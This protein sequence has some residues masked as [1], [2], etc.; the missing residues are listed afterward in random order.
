[1]AFVVR[2]KDGNTKDCMSSASIWQ[3]AIVHIPALLGLGILIY[4]AYWIVGL[5]RQPFSSWRDRLLE[6]SSIKPEALY[7]FRFSSL[8][9]ISLAS[10]FL[11]L[12]LV[13][14]IAS[15]I[16]VFAYFKSL[17]LIACFLGFGLGCY[18][19]RRKVCLLYALGPL[20]AMVALVELP[21]VPLRHLVVNLSGFIGWFSDVHVWGRAYFAGNMLWGWTSAAIA[22][23][24]VIALFGLIAITFV[25]F[26]QLVGWY[27]ER[28]PK[29]ILGYSINVLASVIGIWIYTLLCFLSTPPFV[30]FTLL[31]VGLAVFFWRSRPLR[32]LVVGWSAA[33]LLLFVTG[34]YRT[35]WW[36]EESWK[37]SR[38][39]VYNEKPGKT[40]IFW[41]PYQKLTIV[42]LL[43]NQQVMRYVLNTNDSWYQEVSN[44][45]PE[46]VAKNPSLNVL[47]VPLQFHQ[48]NLP[49]RFYPNPP[50]VLIAGAGMGNDVAGALRNGAGDITAVE[51]DPLIYARGKEL[52]PERPYSSDRVHVR[53]DDAR[54]FIQNTNE[55]F[56]LII[57]SILDSH[58]TSSYY[59]NIRLDNY[60]YTLEAMQ[61]TRT[62]LKPDGVFVM[63]FSSERPWFAGRLRGIVE[64]AFR[65]SPLMVHLAPEFFIVG[66]GH[67]IERA[68]AGNPE[69]K[70]IVE[71]R[72]DVPTAT[73]ELS[74][75][76]WPYLYQQ[77]RGV[78]TI[79]WLLSIGLTLIC[80]M[81]FRRLKSSA[82]GV[83]LH[84][85]FLGAA[86]MLLEV[87][88]ISKAALLF[89]T[90]WLVNSIVISSLLLFILCSNL[91]ISRFPNFP[92]AVAY[93]GL[94]GTLAVSYLLPANL[95]FFDSMTARAAVATA[96]YCSPVFFAGLIF[97]TSFREAGFRAEA[98]GSNLVGSLVGGLLESLS[99][100]IG[101]KA[102]VIVAALLYAASAVTAKTAKKEVPELLP[103]T[104]GSS[105]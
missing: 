25:P 35:H 6:R 69:L 7:G 41:S 77:S 44:L 50:K 57:Y 100:L 96:L 26:G 48:Y 60:V 12:L 29:G 49:Y 59:T 93:A 32:H 74:T 37:G 4:A 67:R 66:N 10:L 83:Q 38:P 101:I 58:T 76:D 8:A 102:L 46:A 3:Q 84:F 33:V 62:L 53:V 51:I 78:P 43:Q 42:P 1:M 65:K 36:G 14:W 68:L 34:E 89:G 16:R 98:L 90:T 24:V 39:E 63:S 13:R 27:L 91:V 17:A 22:V 79:V 73:A 55:K 104:A 61:K 15:E 81:T 19:T 9:L 103:A 18:L 64:Q 40:R 23:A 75:D 21:W 28:S 47:P 71:L 52:H 105:A 20:L 94:F 31:A 85:F 11:E 56:D 88:I 54:A 95:L 86:F 45:T 87:Q 80:W 97:I 5:A 82:D 30:W 70:R 72:S 99:Y 2:R 92:R